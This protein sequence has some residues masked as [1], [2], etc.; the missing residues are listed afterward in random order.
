MNTIAPAQSRSRCTRPNSVTPSTTSTIHVVINDRL[1]NVISNLLR[2]VPCRERH[3]RST[4]DCCWWAIQHLACLDM[5]HA[6]VIATAFSEWARPPGEPATPPAK[7]RPA[8]VRTRA[9]GG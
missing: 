4:V 8:V 9:E 1:T 6:Q 3:G 7:P 5:R 2:E